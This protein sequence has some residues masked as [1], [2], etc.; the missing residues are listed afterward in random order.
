MSTLCR[1]PFTM[2][3]PSVLPFRIWI[4]KRHDRRSCR[5]VLGGRYGARLCMGRG[6][7][8]TGRR[9]VE[10][11]QKGDGSVTVYINTAACFCA[12]PFSRCY[13]RAAFWAGWIST[14]LVS[15]VYMPKLVGRWTRCTTRAWQFGCAWRI[16]PQG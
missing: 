15:V 2:T 8:G 4:M 14:I 1:Q 6:K 16:R 10:E 9:E 3:Q 5:F 12:P 7:A 13:C 11:V